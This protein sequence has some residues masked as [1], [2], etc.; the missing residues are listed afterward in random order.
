LTRLMS[1]EL[2]LGVKLVEVVFGVKLSVELSP[3]CVGKTTV[4]WNIVI[5][6]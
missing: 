5:H 4:I 3:R 6:R 1:M 2:A